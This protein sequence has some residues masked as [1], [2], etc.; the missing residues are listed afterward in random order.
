MTLYVTVYYVFESL[1]CMCLEY[2]ICC[3]PPL[4][5]FSPI[6][7]PCLKFISTTSVSQYT[8]YVLH[9]CLISLSREQHTPITYVFAIIVH[10]CNII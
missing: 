10:I 1:L 4:L 3:D 9:L 6:I 5:L 7:V 8:V 2:I